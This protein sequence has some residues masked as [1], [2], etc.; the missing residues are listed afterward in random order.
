MRQQRKFLSAKFVQNETAKKFLSEM[1]IQNEATKKIPV[2]DASP[3]GDKKE[4]F[5]HF[6]NNVQK[7]SIEILYVSVICFI[8]SLDS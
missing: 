2:G 8:F 4:N 1:L 6:C 7:D 5:C 3:E